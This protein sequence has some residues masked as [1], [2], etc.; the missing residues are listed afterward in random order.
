MRWEVRRLRVPLA[1]TVAAAIGMAGCAMRSTATTRV[2]VDRVTVQPPC[3]AAGQPLAGGDGSTV[4]GL[5]AVLTTAAGAALARDGFD[6]VQVNPVGM[7]GVPAAQPGD[8]TL[9]IRLD[10]WIPVSQSTM[11]IDTVLVELDVT[12]TDPSSGSVLWHAH[13][14]LQPVP[15]YGVLIVGQ[16]YVVAADAVMAEVLAPLRPASGTGH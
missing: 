13:R 2:A 8:A 11:R 7:A 5:G 9:V 15:V 10:R 6:V 14:P 1:A 4:E 16:A 12:L 3:D